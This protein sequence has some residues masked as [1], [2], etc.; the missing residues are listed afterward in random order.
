MFPNS[1][2][3]SSVVDV[4]RTELA[5][6]GVAEICDTECIGI[7]RH[8]DGFALACRGGAVYNSRKV[9]VCVG[10][11]AAPKLG[12]DG[13]GYKILQGMG[14]RLTDV[15]PSLV[16]VKCD[17]RLVVPMKGVKLDANVTAYVNGKCAGKEF[18]EI[19]FTDYGLSGPAV[20]QLSRIASVHTASGDKV[21]FAMDIMPDMTEDELYCHLCMRNKAVPVE[22]FLTGAVNKLIARVLLKKCGVDKFNT[23]AKIIDDNMLQTMAKTMKCWHF[24]ITGT[25]SWQQ[26]QVTAGG[27]ATDG[28][29][30]ATMESCKVRGV[31]AAG[32]VLDI[33]GDCG[34]FNLQ[35]CWSSGYVAGESCAISLINGEK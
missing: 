26:A 35:W 33:D 1:L 18:G 10:G 17:P 22:D 15:Y 13:S 2:Q 29:N 23:T 28:F 25:N 27:I 7:K 6:L 31:Y 3:A 16:Q 11:C 5:S 19:L 14:H 34:G 32:E 30:P 4:M 24:P 21:E 12:T 9:I 20:F 8:N